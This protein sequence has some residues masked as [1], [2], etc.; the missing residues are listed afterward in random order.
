M[1]VVDVQD[2]RS[3]VDAARMASL[4]APSGITA[5]SDMMDFLQSRGILKGETS[6]ISED[7]DVRHDSAAMHRCPWHTCANTKH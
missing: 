7:T 5:K 1:T 2:I 4:V 3:Q 6:L